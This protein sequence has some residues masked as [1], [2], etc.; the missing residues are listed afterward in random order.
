MESTLT[1]PS[2]GH[3]SVETMPTDPCVFFCACKGCGTRH[4][5]SLA[6]VAYSAPMAR[7]R[8]RRS[9]AM[10]AVARA[11]IVKP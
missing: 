11:R 4:K 5:P 9:R 2:C 1:C 3:R 8:A 10:T 6:I 7:S